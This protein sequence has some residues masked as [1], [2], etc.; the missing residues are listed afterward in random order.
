MQYTFSL[1]ELGK[2]N[3]AM[4]KKKKRG[5]K[6]IPKQMNE[7]SGMPNGQ[8]EDFVPVQQKPDKIVDDLVIRGTLII[9]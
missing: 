4:K 9:G 8:T 1:L 6:N 2:N 3:W 5:Y 7:E